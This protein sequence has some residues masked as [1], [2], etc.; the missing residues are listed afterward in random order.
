[1]AEIKER[2][3]M[4][5]EK[6]LNTENGDGM[7]SNVA[8]NGD[9]TGSESV[10][11]AES[12]AVKKE[13]ERKYMFAD[14]DMEKWNEVNVYDLG[15]WDNLWMVYR[16]YSKVQNEID[17]ATKREGDYNDDVGGDQDGENEDE[18]RENH[19]ESKPKIERKKLK[20]GSKFVAKATGT[21]GQKLRKRR[22]LKK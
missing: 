1:M 7:E 16:P 11:S 22:K 10:E 4:E 3:E 20:N 15:T 9:S 6:A 17:A 2:E 12:G 8:A 19:Q 14:F 13:Q 21:R 5:R 18:D